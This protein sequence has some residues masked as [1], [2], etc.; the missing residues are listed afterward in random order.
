MSV[1]MLKLDFKD[2]SSAEVDFNETDPG[3]GKAPLVHLWPA[4][5]TTEDA[6]REKVQSIFDKYFT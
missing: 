4:P 6:L 2:G 3:D 5:S 1:E